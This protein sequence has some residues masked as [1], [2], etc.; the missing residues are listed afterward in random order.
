MSHSHVINIVWS[1]FIF[2]INRFIFIIIIIF[3]NKYI[4]AQDANASFGCSSEVVLDIICY[5]VQ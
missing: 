1:L 4:K 2:S 3:F 5:K